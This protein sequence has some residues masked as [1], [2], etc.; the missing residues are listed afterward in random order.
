MPCCGI[1]TLN[2]APAGGG[3]GSDVVLQGGVFPTIV[4][5]TATGSIDVLVVHFTGASI[6]I[7]TPTVASW[8]TRVNSATL[9]ST[10]AIIQPGVYDCQLALPYGNTNAGA[11]LSLDATLAQR[12]VGPP[13]GNTA[14]VY[15][16]YFQFNTL[17][18]NIPLSASMTVTTAQISAGTNVIRAHAF[19]P[20]FASNP[21]PAVDWIAP[22]GTFLRIIRTGNA[23]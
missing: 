9:G 20:G 18:G 5:V 14:E 21:P 15:A 13:I 22:T 10:F 6:Q 7:G 3:G 11:A 2:G 19:I 17:V 23:A 8:V 4:A 1:N 16:S 12:Q